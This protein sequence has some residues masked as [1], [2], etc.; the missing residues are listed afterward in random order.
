M[1]SAAPQPDWIPEGSLRRLNPALIESAGEIRS[2]LARAKAAG[3]E[4]RRGTNRAAYPEVAKILSVR[5]DDFVVS[6]SNFEDT[7]REQVFLNADVDGVRYFFACRLLSRSTNRLVLR[8]PRIVY[9]WER[10]DRQ[11]KP[12]RCAVRIQLT[13]GRVISALQTNRSDDGLGLELAQGVDLSKGQSV[14]VFGQAPGDG[15]EFAEVRHL[16]DRDRSGKWRRVGLLLTHGPRNPIPDVNAPSGPVVSPRRQPVVVVESRSV[17]FENHRGETIRAI[18]DSVGD[19]QSAVFAVIPPAW[20]RT[21]ESTLAL[22]ETVLATFA[23]AGESAVV[24][25]F[26]GIR[27]RGQSFNEP[28]CLPPISENRRYTFSQGVRDIEAT[29][30]FLESEYRTR[31]GS[32]FLVTL[33]IAAVEG[34]RAIALDEG[35]RIGGW[36]SIVGAVDP[37]SMIRVVSGGVDYFAGAADGLRFGQQ[38]IQGLL[39]DVDGATRDAI[40]SGLAFL[41]DARR[42]M[43]RIQVPT[44]W[45]AGRDDA[46]TDLERVRDIMSIGDISRRRLLHVATGHQLRT[47]EEAMRTFALV[48][49]ELSELAIGRRLQA[50]RPDRE[51]LR[52]KRAAERRRLGVDEIDLKAFWRDY[53]VGRQHDLGIEIVCSTRAFRSFMRAQLEC[54]ALRAG[55]RVLD[56][57]SGAGALPVELGEAVGL[58]GLFVTEA[59]YV[60]EGLRRARRRI[61]EGAGGGHAYS[62]VVASAE[63]GRQR[64]HLP[65]ADS[66]MNA[67]LASLLINYVKNPHALIQELARVLRTG[68]RAVISGMKP[69]ADVSKI[70]VAGVAELRAGGVRSIWSEDEMASLDGPLQEFISSGARLLDLEERGVFTFRPAAELRALVPRRLFKISAVKL[71]YGNPP[72]AIIL[73]LERNREPFS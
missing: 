49:E 39:L 38:Y 34:R 36:I 70:C 25:R 10:R 33:S 21:K 56:V 44:T 64:A 57:G 65:F 3:V 40:D 13:D 61:R 43:A 23:A 46:W 22:S 52:Q 67:V 4:L 71:A 63:I 69:D 1:T 28:D 5:Q 19:P 15:H 16:A 8:I 73:V 45:I 24:V 62:Y 32:I 30:E 27:K 14:R 58:D 51:E 72:Q 41:A 55:D 11:R 7:R 54:L 2:L 17:A 12:T 9:R 48:A 18:V 29:L 47:S 6:L 20:G 50:V 26:D 31:P 53:L 66:S 37:Q 68:G 42:D 35:R 59:D 60:I